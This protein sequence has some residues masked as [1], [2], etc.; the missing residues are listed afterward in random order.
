MKQKKDKIKLIV[1]AAGVIALMAVLTVILLPYIT[2]LSEPEYQETIREWTDSIG[3]IGFFVILGVQML[4]VII[5]FIPGEPVELLAGVLYG[6][7]LGL[8]LC[9]LGCVLASLLVFTLS[10][11]FGKKL[12]DKA[13]G[14]DKLAHW[15]WLQDSKK[16]EL[17]T[18][19][20]FFI[21]GTP[22]DMLT[23][24][25]ALSPIRTP[26]FIGLSTFARIPSVITSTILGSAVSQGNAGA[27][28]AAFAVTGVIGIIGILTKDKIIAFCRRHTP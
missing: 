18:F 15:K 22:K 20:L 1:I 9:L 8:V 26:V 5:A 2:R 3:V 17:V 13:F 6:P 19:L 25:V 16:I 11:K 7:W 14:E 21:P 4:Q 28:I 12:L 10:R 23:Y 27:A 24:V